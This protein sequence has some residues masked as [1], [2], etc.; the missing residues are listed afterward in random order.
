MFAYDTIRMSSGCTS[1]LGVPLNGGQVVGGAG[2]VGELEE[3]L[4]GGGGA[5]LGV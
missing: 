1:E 2:A 3:G 4:F 5:G